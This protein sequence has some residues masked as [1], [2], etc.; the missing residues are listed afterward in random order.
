MINL[1]QQLFQILLKHLLGKDKDESE[2]HLTTYFLTSNER[3][4]HETE[5]RE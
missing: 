2:R 1:D 4:N 5:A 3:N